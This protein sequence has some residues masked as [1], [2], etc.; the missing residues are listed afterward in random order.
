M[1]SRVWKHAM[2]RLKD[3]D[4]SDVV[5]PTARCSLSVTYC[6]VLSFRRGRARSG[7]R[8]LVC[9]LM[10]IYRIVYSAS[11]HLGPEER[12][13]L[14]ITRWGRRYSVICNMHFTQYGS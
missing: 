9:F 13:A 11:K 1:V 8:S 6:E 5:L 12:A 14:V 10:C 3:Q 4:G 7:A 2:K